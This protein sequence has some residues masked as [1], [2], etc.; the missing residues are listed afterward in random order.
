MKQDAPTSIGIKFDKELHELLKSVCTAR[1]EH[2]SNFVRR[3]V[4]KELARLGYMSDD[5]RKALEVD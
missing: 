4:R 1:G 3:S 5:D 2:M